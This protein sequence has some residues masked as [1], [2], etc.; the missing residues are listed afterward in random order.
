MVRSP[1][2]TRRFLT[3]AL[4][5]ALVVLPAAT[6][7]M[8]AQMSEAQKTCCGAMYHDCGDKA[9][10]GV[11][12]SCCVADSP[13][14]LGLTSGPLVAPLAPPVLVLA[15]PLV[16]QPQPAPS[17]VAGPAFTANDPH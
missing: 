10:Q 8:G 17:F 16:A 7:V 13:N 3:W 15:S 12:Q 11:A 5:L 6:C 1:K 2:R 4:A 9:D 14:L